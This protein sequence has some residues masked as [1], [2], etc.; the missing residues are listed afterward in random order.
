MALP[1]VFLT[2]SV[3]VVAPVWLQA[4][5]HCF[6]HYDLGIYTQALARLS[7]REPNPWLSARQVFIFNDHFDPVLW[8][9]R[10]L[11]VF[12]SPLHAGL[13]AEALFVSLSVAPLVW[14]QARGLLDRVSTAFLCA[15]LLLNTS[16]V[17]ALVF[18][19]HPTTWSV[20][21]CVLLAVAYHLRKSG[22][23]LLALVLLF[24]CKEE[25]P[26]AGLMLALGLWWR[27]ERRLALSV[28]AL[29][30]A[31]LLFV[32][33]VRP[34]WWGPTVDYR[35]RLLPAP[36]QDWLA[37]LHSRF[38]PWHLRRMGTL[39]LL[40]VPLGVWA[41]REQWKPDVPWLLMLLPLVAIR[42]AAM[43]WR[44]HYGAPVLALGVLALLPLVRTRR[45]PAWV[46][47][48]TAVLLITTNEVNFRDGLRTLTHPES[49]PRV[50]PADALRL[51]S[52]R[53]GLDV[54]ASRSEGRALL[55]GNLVADLVTRDEVYAVGGPQAEGSLVYDW[56]LVEKPPAG[57][58]LPVTPERMAAL[59]ALWRGEPGAEVLI[60]DAHVFLARGHF[61]VS[62]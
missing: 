27:G 54:L 44:E 5:R 1:V 47:V 59:I 17:E 23:M 8:L 26:L 57:N 53:R 51:A 7:L 10:P 3:C 36:G 56:V 45:P 12:L 35:G 21:P 34:W 41:W 49:F 40:F 30:A 39:L 14:M 18:P 31:W 19:I 22:V 60:D 24:A 61:T 11:G 50:C 33:V 32:M 13:L 20:L 6:T 52:V 37:Y 46:L 29:S 48:S 2:W 58:I 16:I 62:H 28:F 4:A 55:G 15:L 42:V 25:F 9:A 43:A 38:A